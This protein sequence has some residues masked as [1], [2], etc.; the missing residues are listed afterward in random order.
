[1]TRPLSHIQEDLHTAYIN[2]VIANA[3][4]RINAPTG[5]EYGSD[6]IVSSVKKMPNGKY[7]DTGININLQL[8]S[9][10]TAFFEK[11]YV[12]FDLDSTAYQKLLTWEGISPCLLV[13]FKMPKGASNWL[14]VDE[15]GLTLK[16]CC[17]WF[18]VT[19][20]TANKT[21]KRVKIPRVNVFNEL[22]VNRMFDHVK[23]W[24]ELE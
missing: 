22:A 6:L 3:G 13:L 18:K 12:V 9:S 8:K 5:K 21:K 1:M 7:T 15:K 11:D 10:T 24:D 2:A 19:Q 23:K 20:A 4:Y 17:Y 16:E 14:I